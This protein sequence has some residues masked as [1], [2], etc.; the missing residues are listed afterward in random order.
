MCSALYFLKKIQLLWCV[1]VVHKRKSPEAIR[2]LRAGDAIHPVLQKGGLV[3]ETRDNQLVYTCKRMYN[4]W[5]SQLDGH[6]IVYYNYSITV[7]HAE[8]KLIFTYEI[9]DIKHDM[10]SYI[11]QYFVW[12]RSCSL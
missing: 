12:Y 1:C 9:Q 8:V 5:K 6:M 3:H 2:L 4:N 11:Y 10:Y 7:N